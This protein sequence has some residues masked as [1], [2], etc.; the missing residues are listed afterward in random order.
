MD[1]LDWPEAMRAEAIRRAERLGHNVELDPPAG[2][3]APERWTCTICGDSVLFTGA[4]IYGAAAK[5]HCG[6]DHVRY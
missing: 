1:D 6:S 2:P 3:A 4:V 5:R